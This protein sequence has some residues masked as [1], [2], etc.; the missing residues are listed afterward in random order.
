MKASYAFQFVNLAAS[1]LMLAIILR[2]LNAASYAQWVL[3]TT[4][5]GFA[6]QIETALNTLGS[7]HIARSAVGGSAGSVRSAIADVAAAYG[8]FAA[9]AFLAISLG[10]GAFLFAVAEDH[11]EPAWMVQWGLIALANLAHHRFSYVYCSLIALNG[12]DAHG[13]ALIFSRILNLALSLALVWYGLAL[14]GL[15]LAYFA[16]TVGGILLAWRYYRGTLARSAPLAESALNTDRPA[17][18]DWRTILF[19]TAFVFAGY[20][21]YRAGLLVGAAIG[22]AP[23]EQASFGLALQLMAM[24]I[25]IAS[26]P[27]NIR[28]VPLIRAANENDSNG[29]AKALAHLAVPAIAVYVAGMAVIILAGPIVLSLIGSDASLPNLDILVLISIAGLVEI[30]IGL[31]ANV[32]VAIGQFRFVAVYIAVGVVSVGCAALASAEM[33]NVYTWFVMLPLVA[34]LT[35]TFPALLLLMG[36]AGGVTVKD[37]FFAVG[38]EFRANILAPFR[39]R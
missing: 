3:F 36:K 9:G 12:A 1:I 30:N 17:R 38:A 21:L 25:A 29:I 5:T 31:I 20:L 22:Q 37:Y 24:T 15:S 34:Q 19:Q 33:Q 4:L 18:F 28:I 14:T 16:G 39:A 11:F 2:Y 26:V 13:R 23:E 32:M 7:R 27:V 8:W 35:V 6:V 10:G